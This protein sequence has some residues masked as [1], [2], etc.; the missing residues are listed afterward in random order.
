MGAAN[1]G[2]AAQPSVSVDPSGNYV[3]PPTTN[4]NGSRSVQSVGAPS[5][6]TG[7][8][9]VGTS[10]TLIAAARTGRQAITVVST[11]ALVFYVGNTGVTTATGQYVAAAAG[12]SITINTSAAIYGVAAAPVTV[13]YMEA[14]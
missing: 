4:A 6:A 8:V 11:T 2:G 7:Q 3:T 12:A 14:F 5:I 1:M 13:S 9:S 10:S